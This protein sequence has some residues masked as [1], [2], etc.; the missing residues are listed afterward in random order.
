LIIYQMAGRYGV[1]HPALIEQHAAAAELAGQIAG[2][3]RWEWM[4]RSENTAADLLARGGDPASTPTRT[5]LAEPALV[6]PPAPPLQAA[7]SRLNAH[8]APGFGDL[9]RLRVGGRDALSEWTLAALQTRT[10][11]PA[12]AAVQAA[13][14]TAPTTQAAV[15]RWALRGLAVELAIQKGQIDLEIQQ[16]AHPAGGNGSPAPSPQDRR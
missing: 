2:G 15:L 7:I 16:R 11:A 1:R 5:L 4:R 9:A 14:P 12:A 10:G 6:V 8:P 3:V 13:F